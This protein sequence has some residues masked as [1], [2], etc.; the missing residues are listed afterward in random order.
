M[1]PLRDIAGFISGHLPAGSGGLVDDRIGTEAC[2]QAEL[3]FIVMAC[4]VATLP[5]SA[6]HAC[7]LIDRVTLETAAVRRP[8]ASVLNAMA[9]D[10]KRRGL[11]KAARKE[12]KTLLAAKPVPGAVL[13]RH[14]HVEF[15]VFD[16]RLVDLFGELCRDSR[17]AV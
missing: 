8:S 3:P 9:A 7:Y 5:C 6:D 13:R 1:R 14:G 15:V 4:A 17:A 16:R 12:A 11:A 10:G 2:F